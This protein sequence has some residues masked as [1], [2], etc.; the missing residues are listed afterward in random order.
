MAPRHKKL[1]LLLTVWNPYWFSYER[2]KGITAQR[3]FDV[4]RSSHAT[5]RDA[6]SV[7]GPALQSCFVGGK[8]QRQNGCPKCCHC[9]HTH[10]TPHTNAGIPLLPDWLESLPDWM[11]SFP[12]WL[13]VKASH[14]HH[15]ISDVAPLTSYI[16]LQTSHLTPELTLPDLHLTP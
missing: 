12:V 1:V 2:H 7:L 6:H 15:R 5:R 4:Y 13:V 11:D 10:H 3:H 14:T 8:A 9:S 16:T